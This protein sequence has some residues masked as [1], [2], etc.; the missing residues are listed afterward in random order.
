MNKKLK[1]EHDL[2]ITITCIIG[3]FLVSIGGAS[4]PWS[5]GSSIYNYLCTLCLSPLMLR[6]WTPSMA[7]CIRYNISW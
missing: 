1:L 6:V 4:W 3:M 5:Y 7:R 2:A